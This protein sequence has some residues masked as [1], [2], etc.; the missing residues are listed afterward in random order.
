MKSQQQKASAP[1]RAV[2]IRAAALPPLPNF[3]LARHCPACAAELARQHCK[4]ICPR[5]GFF[6]DCGEL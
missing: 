5:C 6:W 2:P 1:A 4:A 3:T